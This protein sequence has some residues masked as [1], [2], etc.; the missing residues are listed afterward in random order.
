MQECDVSA[1]W[2]ARAKSAIRGTINVYFSLDDEDAEEAKLLGR[3]VAKACSCAGALA[4]A[5][6]KQLGEVRQIR[7]KPYDGGFDAATAYAPCGAPDS[8]EADAPAL[9]PEPVEVE[10]SVDVDCSLSRERGQTGLFPRRHA[11]R[12]SR[13]GVPQAF[14]ATSSTIS[15]AYK[16]I[17]SRIILI[18]IILQYAMT[19]RVPFAAYHIR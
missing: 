7:N 5:A 2:T 19:E 3:A 17:L 10:C 16:I 8:A 18:R 13:G 14:V 6:G 1:I 12:L 4:T 9:N 11:G 15:A